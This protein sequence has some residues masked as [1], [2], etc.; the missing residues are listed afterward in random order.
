MLSLDVLPSSLHFTTK[1]AIL[2]VVVFA[3]VVHWIFRRWEPIQIIPVCSLIIGAPTFLSRLFVQQYGTPCA[4]LLTF[5]VYYASIAASVIAYRV[6]PFHP[7]AR[8]PGPMVA[9]LSAFWLAWIAFRG[10]RHLYIDRLH[11]QHGDIVRIGPNELS[12]RDASAIF[13]LMGSNGLPKGFGMKGRVQHAESPLI[14]CQDPIE[15]ARRRRPWNRAFNT[16]ALRDYQPIITRRATQLVEALRIQAGNVDLAQWISFF[17]YDFMGDMAFGGGTEMLRDGD[18]DGLWKLLKAGMRIAVIYEHVPWLSFYTRH[19]PNIGKALVELRRMAYER[20]AK[21]YQNGSSTKDLFFFLSNEDNAEK[22]SPPRHI[23]LADGV[24]AVIAGSDTTATTLSNLFFNL[25]N[26]PDTYKRLQAEVDHYY[27]RGD[28]ALNP[29]HY[30]HMSYLDAII[31][32]TMRLFPAVPSGSL[33]APSRGSGGKA[34]GK[35]FIPEGTQVRISIRSVQRDVRNFSNP[36]MFWPDRWLIAEGLLPPPTSSN[37]FVH[38]VNAFIPFSF[39]PSN[40]VGK[41]LALLEMRMVICLCMQKLEMRFA[42]SWDP[43]LWH[44]NLEDLFVTGMGQLP[45]VITRRD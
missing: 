21:R 7:L 16:N 15:H 20:T 26:H 41:N 28:D 11:T 45:V 5:T 25:L 29:I 9:K 6:S 19:L 4:M 24:L 17:A 13:P 18:K 32:E 34:F 33:R 31:N 43:K 27:P 22:V 12:I 30:T 37:P 38:D 3:L 14:A 10:K 8:Y 44:A 23:V 39:G 2:V 40:C 1:D 42:E 36:D 35:H